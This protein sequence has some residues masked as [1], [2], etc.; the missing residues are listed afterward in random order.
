VTLRQ[1]DDGAVALGG[2]EPA[3]TGNVTQRLAASNRLT[4]AV[5]EGERPLADP[6]GLTC[7]PLP[8]PRSTAVVATAA[9]P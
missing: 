5:V 3:V 6:A 8:P 9:Q 7:V 4:R 1:R 2:Y